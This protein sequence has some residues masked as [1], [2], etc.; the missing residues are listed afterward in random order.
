VNDSRLPAL[1]AQALELQAD[2]RREFLAALRDSDPAS[3]AGLEVLL[4]ASESGDWEIDRSPWR[5][6][7]AEPDSNLASSLP[8]RIGPYRLLRELGRGGM[9]RVFLAEEETADFRR[10]VALKVID[11]P[12]LTDD[13]IRRFREEVRILASLEHPGIARFFDG[14]RTGDGTW[15]LAL[16]YVEGRDLLA[17]VRERGLDLGRRVE[18]FLQVLDAVDFAHRCLVVHRDLKPGNVL[19]DENG[20]AKLLD[21]GISKVLEDGSPDELATRTGSRALT[22]AYASPEQL[23]GERVTIASDIYSLGV[24]LY[25]LLCGRR[26]F[27]G[28]PGPGLR[29]ATDGID[30]EPPS[31]AARRVDPSTGDRAPIPAAAPPREL[32]G[33]L[34]AIVLKALRAEPEGRYPSAVAL[35]D[36]LRRWGRGEAVLARRGGRR[37]RLGKFLR[38]NRIPVAFAALAVAALVAG[39][40]GIVAQSR[41]ASRAAALAAEQRDFALRQ[42]SRAEAINELNSFL[43]ADAAPAGRPFTAGALLDR[44]EQIVA[45]QPAAPAGHQVEMMIAVGRE[46]HNQDQIARARDLLTRAYSRARAGEE[47]TTRARAACALAHTLARGGEPLRAEEL[48]AEGLALLTT[49]PLHALS[50][51]YCLRLGGEV[52]REAEDGPL[53]VERTLAAQRLSRESG[54][55]SDLLDARLAADL[56]ESLRIAGRYREAA[57]AFAVAASRLEELGYADSESAGT[58]FNNWALAVR[59]QGRPLEAERLF[60]RA[61][62]IATASDGW[63]SVPPITLTNLGYVLSDLDRHE[64]ARQLSDRAFELALR[65]Q[66]EGSLQPALFL[67]AR[68]RLR[69]GRIEEA[70][71]LM[72][73]LGRRLHALPP[74]HPTLATFESQMGL[75]AAERGDLAAAA[76][77]Q[78]RAL[79]MVS[80]DPTRSA[81]VA[82]FKLRRA[83]VAL[84]AGRPDL[85]RDDAE[86]ALELHSREVEPGAPSFWVGRS[87][88][89]VAR[90]QLALGEVEAARGRLTAA[91]WNLEPTLGS[92]HPD[93]AAA[94]Q[95]LGS[96]T[97]GPKPPASR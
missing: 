49:D 54:Q 78:G 3:A 16:E 69:T 55:A 27:P 71:E 50:R 93:C 67:R 95:L 63:D 77:A 18:L 15:F 23:R 40:A 28:T 2:A 80:A 10:Q 83:A 48:V 82:V 33:D 24:M 51:I 8:E 58:L 94:R 88:L 11:G 31:L 85:A 52:A 29:S 62:E 75:L 41:R 64:E 1:F 42:A 32:A 53:A 60:R 72:A 45:R 68:T 76:A 47:P 81:Q 30:P 6:D 14:G 20:R 19:V 4:T 87:L 43:L 9:G 17:F 5:A 46:L 74:G 57:A 12:L 91:L 44:A 70:A 86:S 79:A 39:L 61:V 21:F 22:P 25:E 59:G 34:D 26:P 36:D 73:Q 13:S 96:A 56:A 65:Q 37:Y 84:A 97:P 92:D 90:A 7:G 66:D 38:R 89:T 35:A